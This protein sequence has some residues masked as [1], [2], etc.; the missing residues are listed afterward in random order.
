MPGLRKDVYIGCRW[1][2]YILHG[3]CRWQL[4]YGIVLEPHDRGWSKGVGQ[5]SDG[6]TERLAD[7]YSADP[8]FGPPAARAEW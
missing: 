2:G 4:I 7:K 6:R 8:K 1:S 3:R 5:T